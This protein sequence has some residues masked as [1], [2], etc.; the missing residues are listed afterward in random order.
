MPA[1]VRPATVVTATSGAGA[2]AEAMRPATAAIPTNATAMSRR[3]VA[4][5]AM[6]VTTAMRPR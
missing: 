5:F 3:R 2:D 6:S 1:A 4:L